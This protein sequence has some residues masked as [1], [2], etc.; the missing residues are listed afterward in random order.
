MR[1][2][3]AC[4]ALLL[5][6]WLAACGSEPTFDERYARQ[7]QQLESEARAMEAELERRMT[8]K[9]GVEAGGTAS[10]APAED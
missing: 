10:E 2:H 3:R 9:P 5:L 4:C 1:A 8:A 7:Q 6:S